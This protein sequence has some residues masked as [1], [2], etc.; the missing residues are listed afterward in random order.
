M[1]YPILEDSTRLPVAESLIHPNPHARDLTSTS[2]R[3]MPS[4]LHQ[5][6][7]NRSVCPVR[8]SVVSAERKSSRHANMQSGSLS[9]GV[10][11]YAMTL[12]QSKPAVADGS[13]LMLQTSTKQPAPIPSDAHNAP[14]FLSIV[15][16]RGVRWAKW[17]DT[18]V[19]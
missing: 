7:A 4:C 14:R 5:A 16:R 8:H 2:D 10:S 3:D 15:S 9:T 17:A 1:L 18:V 12:K 13:A 11:V 19:H 6:P